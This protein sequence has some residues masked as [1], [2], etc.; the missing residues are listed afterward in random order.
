MEG[1]KMKRRWICVP[2]NQE[3]MDKNNYYGFT[4]EDIENGELFYFLELNEDE[5]CE[6]WNNEVFDI[7]NSECNSIIDDFED[8]IIPYEQLQV[9]YDAVSELN[10]KLKSES[11]FKLLKMFKLAIEHETEIDFSF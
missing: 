3:A 1:C 11:I 8:E 10:K 9:A 5:F 4:Q 2:K 6:L 7:I